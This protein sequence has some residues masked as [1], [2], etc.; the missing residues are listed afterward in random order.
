M[1]HGC[2]ENNA[3]IVLPKDTNAIKAK[4]KTQEKK[5]FQY[6]WVRVV[7]ITAVAAAM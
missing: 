1:S 6:C 2:D 7:L 5:T 4:A 3:I